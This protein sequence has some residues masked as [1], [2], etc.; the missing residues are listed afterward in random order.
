[1][2]PQVGGSYSNGKSHSIGKK[3]IWGKQEIANTTRLNIATLN[4]RSLSKDEKV[5][6]LEEDIKDLKWDIIGLAEEKRKE[7]ECIT[8]E[9]GNVLY[10]KGREEQS[11][12]GVG[13][14]IFKKYAHKVEQFIGISEMIANCND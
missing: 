13:F 9:S 7:E 8:L 4:I 10:Y 12:Y 1:M 3:D 2:G 5:H 14:L 6:E 11:L